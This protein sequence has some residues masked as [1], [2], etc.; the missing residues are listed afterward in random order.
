[1][2]IPAPESYVVELGFIACAI[3]C[4]R[5]GSHGT[6][7]VLQSLLLLLSRQCCVEGKGGIGTPGRWSARWCR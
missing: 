6:Q 4:Q 7:Y 2:Q 5:A 3:G 1:M